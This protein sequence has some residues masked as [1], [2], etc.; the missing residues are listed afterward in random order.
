MENLKT[1][2][3]LKIISYILI[4]IL[5]A[6]IGLSVLHLAFLNEYGNSEETKY[7]ETEMFAS[8]YLYFIIDQVS[9]CYNEKQDNSDYFMIVEDN[10]GNKYNYSNHN[11]GYSRYNDIGSYIDYIIIDKET[12]EIYTNIRSNDYN[13]EI[14]NMKNAENHWNYTDENIDTDIKYINTDNIIYNSVYQYA[15]SDGE[16]TYIVNKNITGYDIYSRYNED[17]VNQLTN[18]E[19][20]KQMYNFAL[21]NQ[22]LPVYVLPI[23]TFLLLVIVI[24]LLWAIGHEKGK[25]EIQLNT[26]DSIPY[27]ILLIFAFILVTIFLTI[28]I[29]ILN[30]ANYI[31]L[32][33]GSVFYVLCYLICAV[34][35]VTT[36]KRIKAKK[37]L[38]S[39]LIYSI[40]KWVKRKYENAKK[41]LEAKVENKKIFWYY[42]GF[43]L[44]SIIL[45]G[46]FTTGLAIIALIVFWIWTYYKIKQYNKRQEEIRNALKDIYN[47]KNNVYVNEDE[48]QGI[49]K[50]MA[51]YVNDISGGFS[52]AIEE[53]L[54][55]ERLKTELIT[56][57][58]HDIKTPLT[59]IIN[60]VD[61]LKKENIENEK[62]KE[63]IDIL[64]KKSQRLKKL[65]EDL[66]EA[67]KA[68]SGNVKLN[69]EEINIKELIN[70]TIGEFKDK[71]EEK[72]LTIET[73]MPDQELIIKADN[74]YIYRIIENLFSNV[75]KYAQ[76]NSRVY[77][78]IEKNK[79]SKVKISIKNISK[80]K[81]NISSDELMQRFVRGDKS[82]YT[83]G[84]GLGLS[85]AKSLT[86]LQKGKFDIKIDGDLFRVDME[87]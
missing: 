80:E 11:Y 22:Q 66:V 37:F 14:E 36:I 32:I 26:I 71:F 64:D 46:F 81:L 68:S 86:E 7:I 69:I 61:L 54:K 82:R 44:I 51:I 42:W 28:T 87:W 57:V 3:A 63:Y 4:P 25:E 67:S 45:A 38:K 29:Q 83:E 13:K 18:F 62:V 77:I 73:T 52:N 65:T 79:E 12:N 84:S 55:S 59:S 53:S 74:R 43:V 58:S 23:S 20:A 8:D 6:I 5:V 78:D 24:Y 70:Q 75:T 47:G 49:L 41:V 76:E 34:V 31:L 33:L 60:Y 30:F 27:E 9:I 72:G 85:I 21:N 17:K 40:W 1:S 15:S 2:K 16:D 48:L 35:A 10:N 19:L 56:N 39:F 50:E